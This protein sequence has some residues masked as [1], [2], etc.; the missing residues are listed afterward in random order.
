MSK[1]SVPSELRDEEERRKALL[2]L[3]TD[4]YAPT[5]ATAMQAKQKTIRTILGFWDKQE[6]PLT[7]DKILALAA[8][9]KKGGYRSATSYLELY[10]GV[11]ERSGQ[12][13]TMF[14]QRAMR[15]CKRSCERGLGS[16]TRAMPL[17][18]GRLGEL[19]YQHP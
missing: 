18:F 1:G 14:E 5:T 4:I 11:A 19:P 6:L 9:L 10:K 2:A 16:A 15:D 3:R 13:M 17:P 12:E 8:G 7:V